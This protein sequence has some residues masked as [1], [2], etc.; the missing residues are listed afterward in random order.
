MFWRGLKLNI[1][2]ILVL[3]LVT[4]MILID[5]VL[6]ISVQGILL[7]SEISKAHLFI[8]AV[9]NNLSLSS[10]GEG[11]MLNSFLEDSFNKMFD[12]SGIFCTLILDKE[13]KQIYFAGNCIP[14]QNELT[15]SVRD[16]IASGK[17][18]SVYSGTTWGVFWWQ[19]QRL[20][21]SAPLMKHNRI[22]AGIGIVVQLEGI[23]AL[24]RRT[25][26]YM[27]IYI[28][29][30][31]VFLTLIGFYRLSS[32]AVKPV[33]KLLQRTEDYRESDLDAIF[34][35]YEGD[36]FHQLSKTMTNMIE[37]I[38]NDKK[39]LEITVRSLEKA[40]SDLK[41][42]QQNIIRAE[43]LASVGR[44]AAGIAHEIGN[45][46]AIVVGYLELLKQDDIEDADKK[47]FIHRTE[48]EVNRINT[49][50][51]QLLDFSRPSK[52]DPKAVSVHEIILDV[53]NIL[54]YQKIMSKIR[55][56]TFLNAEQ[57]QVIAD[58]GQLRQIFLNLIINAADAIAEKK[59]PDDGEI[60][61]TTEISPC[62]R[63][64]ITFSDN[65]TG[66]PP[67]HLANI[68]DPFYTTKEP[69]KGTGFGLSVCFMI[70]ESMGGSIQAFSEQSQGT[71]MVI[72][73]PL[74]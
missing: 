3:V 26:Y 15:A 29:I 6:I 16:A 1:T 10:Q 51:R 23:Y 25:Q 69:G 67:Q 12:E 28:L 71:H 17:Q 43:K 66:I 72:D 41:Q 20:M 37:R 27:L 54:K 19:K 34:S 73:L 32:V 11:I 63:L 74:S 4:G 38:S 48:S 62:F 45:P 44:L 24:L 40:N 52:G 33:H 46:I 18:D 13:R 8:S 60:R 53:L 9:E 7:K 22:V 57:D 42:A 65:G 39:E 2:I 70:I 68:F 49:I 56:E 35:R 36:E 14:F 31:T 59:S 30:N 55:S 47:D 64:K 5:F 50:I 21:L 61:I 58:A